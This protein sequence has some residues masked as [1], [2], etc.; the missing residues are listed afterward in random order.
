MKTE[1]ER[2]RGRYGRAGR[3][4][5]NNRNKKTG[6]TDREEKNRERGREGE[7]VRGAGQEATGRRVRPGNFYEDP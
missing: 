7:R 3:M 1:R 6:E 4:R 2:E 5:I